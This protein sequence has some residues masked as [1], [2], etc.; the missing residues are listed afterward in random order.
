MHLVRFAL[1]PAKK[2]AHAVPTIV[3]VIVVGVFAGALFSANDKILI[4]FRSFLE[5]NIDIDVPAR[6]RSKKIL[7]RFTKFF[8]AENAHNTLF[9][10]QLA[11]WNCLV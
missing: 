4:D 1:E 5:R 6:A 9:D 10:T 11:I 7:L 8:A 3:F 2:A